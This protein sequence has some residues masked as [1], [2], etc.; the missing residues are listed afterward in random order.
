MKHINDMKI[1]V[2][3]D[4][5]PS[6][7]NLRLESEHGLSLFIEGDSGERILCDMGRGEAFAH[8]AQRM[9]LS[10]DKVDFA[11]L[12]HAHNDHAG[13][14]RH[15]LENSTDISLYLSAESFAARLF[16]HRHAGQ[17]RD[18]S[19]DF[20]IERDFAYRL[21][22]IEQSCWI[23]GGVAAVRS[24]DCG[25]AQPLGNQFL[26]SQRGAAEVKDDFC[27]ELSLAFVTADGLVIVASCSHLGA[28]N[29][30]RSCQQFTGEQR[31]RAFIGGLH[32]VEGVAPCAEA[33]TLL[34]DLAQLA[35]EAEIFTG[36][37]TCDEAK[38]HLTSIGKRVHIFRTGSA[39]IL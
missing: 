32:F 14:L 16:S 36:H 20:A 28:A 29:I 17:V 23:G 8:N 6:D 19:I 21:H 37:C 2:L 33:E 12:S 38:Q 30:I 34:T 4:N 9:G 35:P 18:I 22:P 31:V 1:T 10:L 5:Q 27:H 13:G 15:W 7:G 25:F 39:I 3:V 26:T 24:E 11:F